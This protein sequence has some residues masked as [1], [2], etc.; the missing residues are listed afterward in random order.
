MDTSQKS[1]GIEIKPSMDT[2]RES[3][4]IE[5]QPSFTISQKRDD[6][7]S[8][9]YKYITIEKYKQNKPTISWATDKD[10]FHSGWNPMVGINVCLVDKSNADEKMMAILIE[11]QA[12]LSKAAFA[13]G[14]FF[15]VESSGYMMMTYRVKP[16]HGPEHT[17]VYRNIT[18]F[19]LSKEKNY[20]DP[21]EPEFMEESKFIVSNAWQDKA[22]RTGVNFC[23]PD[24]MDFQ[25]VA[26]HVNDF[27]QRHRQ[28]MSHCDVPR[29]FLMLQVDDSVR[30]H[31][32]SAGAG[33]GIGANCP[34]DMPPPAV[35]SYIPV[36]QCLY[37][38]SPP[39][40]ASYDST[41]QLHED[42]EVSVKLSVEA[43]VV[44]DQVRVVGE[45]VAGV[46]QLI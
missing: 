21:N 13:I 24:F 20:T 22:L 23:H 10:I 32:A 15:S 34:Y 9:H 1:G 5:I 27:I 3:D 40:V 29:A 19:G 25:F 17:V 16:L 11:R 4:G 36:T 28:E 39:A 14:C 42:A 8:A 38:M 18:Y 45:G 37:D 43:T 41:A 46:H 7:T 44:G 35:A 12:S 31:S 2:S 6:G 26:V 30:Q 33:A